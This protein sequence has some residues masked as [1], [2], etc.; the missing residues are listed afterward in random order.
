M[1]RIKRERLNRK[2][3][4]ENVAQQIGLTR[5]AVH[6][7]ETGKQLPSY[8]ILVKLEDLFGLPHRELFAVATDETNQT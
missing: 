1:L 5:T 8:K 4:Q 2:W 7:L 3:T 6:D